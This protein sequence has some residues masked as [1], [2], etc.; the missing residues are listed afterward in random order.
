MLVGARTAA[1]A[2]HRRTD[3]FVGVLILFLR[4]RLDRKKE[5]R[6]EGLF[7]RIHPKTLGR[8][9]PDNFQVF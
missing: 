4:S 1:D 3:L 8:T 6:A 9:P 5:P 7:G 2:L